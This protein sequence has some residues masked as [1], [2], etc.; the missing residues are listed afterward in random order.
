MEHQDLGYKMLKNAI[1]DLETMGTP[2]SDPRRAG[3]NISLMVAP[4]PKQR[5]KLKFS[6]EVE[7]V[8]IDDDEEEEF[9]EEELTDDDETENEDGE[10]EKGPAED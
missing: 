2:D 8:L 10:Q 7:E 1:K 9:P 4:L 6:K 3:R 5:Q